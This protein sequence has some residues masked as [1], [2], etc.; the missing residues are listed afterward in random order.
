M[1]GKDR[2]FIL[3]SFDVEEFD[4][5]LN[6]GQSVVTDEQLEIGHKGLQTVMDMLETFPLV[7]ATFFTTGHFANRYP[8][9]IYKISLHHEIAS[10]SYFNSGYVE[11]HLFLSK[12]T[13]ESITQQPVYGLR[14]P[15]MSEVD[16]EMVKN[17]PYVYDSSINP[18]WL[19]TRY[20][21]LQKP[22]RF[23]LENG[24]IRI[25]ASVST[26]LRI[27]LFW[28]SFKT[29]PYK[30]FSLLAKATLKTDGYLC[31]YFHPWEFV[32]ITSYQIPWY[33]KRQCKGD[34]LE[35]MAR[36]IRELS[37]EADFITMYEFSQYVKRGTL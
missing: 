23:F 6:Y 8:N 4:M 35:K 28:L 33:A 22:R 17:T 16:I 10:H 26:Y 32:D 1:Q 24:V 29:F 25:P 5:P 18:T 14:M 34:L 3:L 36:L 20:N 7:K 19:P 2:K 9:S 27:P 31:L 11:N 37:K 12:Q 13:L 30:L 15:Q 21:N